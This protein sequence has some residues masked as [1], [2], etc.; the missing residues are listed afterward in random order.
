MTGMTLNLIETPILHPCAN[1]SLGTNIS[2]RNAVSKY[3]LMMK[4]K[5]L[6]SVADGRQK[7]CTTIRKTMPRPSSSG[8]ETA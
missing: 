7:K 6:T 5:D 4:S 8:W 3:K 2:I 1:L